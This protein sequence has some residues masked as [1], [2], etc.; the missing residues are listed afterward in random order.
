MSKAREL[1]LVSSNLPPEVGGPAKFTSEFATWLIRQGIAYAVITTK[2]EDKDISQNILNVTSI[3]RKQNILFRFFRTSILMSKLSRGKPALVNGLFYEALISHLLFKFKFIAKVP[4]DIVWDRAR[5][6][7][8]TTLSVDGFQGNERGSYRIQ[9]WFYTRSLKAAE[10]VIVPSK[11]LGELVSNWGI[12]KNR[13]ILIRNS[14][15]IPCKPP[16]HSPT[17]DVISV[18]RLIPLKGNF[19][20]ITVCAKLGYSL[21]ILGDGPEES[22]LKHLASR[23]G[24]KVK[25]LGSLTSAEVLS[26][27]NESRVFAL[28]SS[29]E[30]SPNA[31]I[32]AMAQ[33]AVCVVREN[34]GTMEL[35]DDLQTGILVG[36]TRN[37]EEALKMA[38]MDSNI[39]QK[40]GAGAYSFAK[41]ELNQD[42]NFKRILEFCESD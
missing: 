6:Q 13:I 37:L 41:E 34:P 30:G 31:L 33:G 21:R 35:I 22:E 11:H 1:L 20:L 28:N 15:L 26:Q 16:A 18:G 12:D 24:A 19:E 27:V 32:E 40:V 7:G 5:D 39:R 3:S 25:F 8:K 4:S 9:R 29:H 42:I 38:M 23:L 10:K 17:V 14:Q 2:A 36:K